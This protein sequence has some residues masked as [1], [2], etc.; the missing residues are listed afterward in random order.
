MHRRSRFRAG[1]RSATDRGAL[2]G[3]LVGWRPGK[4]HRAEDR[5]AERDDEGHRRQRLPRRGASVRRGT[6]RLPQRSPV[7]QALRHPSP[8]RADVICQPRPLG[9]E[10]GRGSRDGRSLSGR[11]HDVRRLPAR[12]R[13]DRWLAEGGLHDHRGVPRVLRSARARPDRGEP[14]RVPRAGIPVH[15]RATAVHARDRVDAVARPLLPG[16]VARARRGRDRPDAADRLG[17]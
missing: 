15:R 5:D 13:D 14:V 6:W 9:R 11:Q 12:W 7:E 8:E 16:V 17:R 3:R 1:N 10:H 4:Q 2:L